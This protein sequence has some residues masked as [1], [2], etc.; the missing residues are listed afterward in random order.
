MDDTDKLVPNTTSSSRSLFNHTGNFLISLDP[1]YINCGVV[2]AVLGDLEARVVRVTTETIVPGYQP[3]EQVA[4]RILAGRCS[5]LFERLVPPN[6][7][8]TVLIEHQFFLVKSKNAS[9]GH[10]LV[11]LQQ[12]LTS[13]AL[14]RG[15]QIFETYPK[16][17]KPS[18]KGSY[19]DRKKQTVE[20]VNKRH[21]NVVSNDH[22]ADAVRYL[23]H[24]LG[25][26]WQI[27]FGNEEN[28]LR[29]KGES[30][31]S[32]ASTTGTIFH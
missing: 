12:A 14:A 27:K 7:N 23:E 1:G 11:L 18:F 10:G 6:A 29:S 25:R 21:G 19:E 9:L 28:I 26:D 31:S 17:L 2:I 22:E 5:A 3:G 13:A 15:A 32:A 8:L 24:F 16:D 20:Y 30:D 4:A